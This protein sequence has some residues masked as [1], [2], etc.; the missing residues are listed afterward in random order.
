M[1]LDRDS[2]V[3]LLAVRDDT[4]PSPV[5]TSDFL[6]FLKRVHNGFQAILVKGPKALVDEQDIHVQV[7]AIQGGQ[8]QGQCQGNHEALAAGEDRCRTNLIPVVLVL[9]KNGELFI[10]LTAGELI[11]VCY[12]GKIYIGIVQVM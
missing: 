6:E 1:N 9:D 4:Y 11:T 10:I 12:L 3:Q 7:R 5:L 8:G 2:L